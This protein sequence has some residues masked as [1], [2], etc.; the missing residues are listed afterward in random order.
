MTCPPRWYRGAMDTMTHEVVEPR[1]ASMTRSRAVALLA[2][3]LACLARGGGVRADGDPGPFPPGR[4]RPVGQ[5]GRGVGRQPRRARDRAPR[6]RGRLRHLRHDHLDHA[7]R[8]GRGE[9]ATLPRGGV[10]DRGDGRGVARDHGHQA[11]AR[12]RPPRVAGQRGRAHLQVL[13]VRSR[14]LEC[15]AGRN[16]DPP[17]VELLPRQSRPRW[18][19][20]AWP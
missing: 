19:V 4:L 18:V 6:R 2:C 13:P 8:A 14:V 9:P 11:V 17:G 5:A 1:R 20:T 7:G 12:P 16:P 15:G 3:A 10:R